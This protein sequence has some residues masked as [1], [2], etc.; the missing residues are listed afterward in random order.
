MSF[1]TVAPD[2]LS[3]AAAEVAR[4]GSFV[5]AANVAAATA[6]TSVAAAAEDE[7]SAAIAALFG[8]HGQTYQ[9]VSDRVAAFHDRFVRT[10]NAG[11]GGY[12]AAE[13]VNAEQTLAGNSLSPAV[14]QTGGNSVDGAGASLASGNTTVTSNPAANSLAGNAA[15]SAT[16]TATTAAGSTGPSAAASGS[17]GLGNQGTAGNSG[18]GNKGS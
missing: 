8:A 12:A 4:I 14:G 1:T 18:N 17:A 15:A 10:L 2:L 5:G 3:L 13:A 7:V 16:T 11:A 6:T 9:S